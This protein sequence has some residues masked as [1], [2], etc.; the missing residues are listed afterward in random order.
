MEKCGKAECYSCSFKNRTLLY[1]SD[2][3]NYDLNCQE[4]D[5]TIDQ[6]GD[7]VMLS[8]QSE[9]EEES[10]N[11]D[12]NNKEEVVL[13]KVCLESFQFCCSKMHSLN[14][15]FTKWLC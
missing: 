9:E 13:T 1:G 4:D 6:S 5:N 12:D 15:N 8:L 10:E 3:T 7:S 2:A 14:I 11:E